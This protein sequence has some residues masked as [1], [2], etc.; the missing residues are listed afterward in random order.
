MA[1]LGNEDRRHCRAPN[2]NISC[3]QTPNDFGTS[4]GPANDRFDKRRPAPQ[5]R[6]GTV[7]NEAEFGPQPDV[8]LRAAK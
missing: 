4:A 8:K 2:H 3:P 1:A 6:S 5:G 7:E